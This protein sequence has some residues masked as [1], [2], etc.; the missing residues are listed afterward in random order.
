MRKLFFIFLLCAWACHSS[1]HTHI[2]VPVEIIKECKPTS[3]SFYDFVEDWY[4]VELENSALSLLGEIV[5]VEFDSVF[6]FVEA[7]TAGENAVFVF[8]RTGKF[9]NKVGTKGRGPAE[10]LNIA[11]WTVDR[12]NQEILLLDNFLLQIKKFSYSGEFLGNSKVDATFRFG[13]DLLCCPDGNIVLQNILMEGCPY[14]F[15]ILD[16]EFKELGHSAG[17]NMKV[18]GAISP[19]GS[20]VYLNDTCVYIVPTFDDTIYTYRDS[21]FIPR[22]YVGAAQ[23]V[24]AYFNYEEQDYRE[25]RDRFISQ[26]YVSGRICLFIDKYIF[27]Q[28]SG[29]DI[30]WNIKEQKGYELT[31][32]KKDEKDIIICPNLIGAVNQY[33]VG[34]CPA[35]FL[36]NQK[37]SFQNLFG[38]PDRI[39]RVFDDLQEDSNPVLFFY[40]LKDGVKISKS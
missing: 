27:I 7:E 6:I 37:K 13:R 38:I 15:R 5:K 32:E 26:G 16:R 10:Y 4:C 29:K 3:L 31:G 1:K 22:Y 20:G 18:K 24:P 39:R 11:A 25:L 9:H 17:K 40:K 14:E 35:L 36:L 34:A 33:A 28:S 23:T 2:E 21:G 19:L 8:D 12:R 30:L